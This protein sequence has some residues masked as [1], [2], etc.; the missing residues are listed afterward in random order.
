MRLHGIRHRPPA[1]GRPHAEGAGALVVEAARPLGVVARGAW[2]GGPPRPHRRA[3]SDRVAVVRRGR[4]EAGVLDDARQQV[5]G[6]E[7]PRGLGDGLYAP[8]LFDRWKK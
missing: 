2:A 6:G 5:A 8:P 7:A 3:I 4:T 1:P